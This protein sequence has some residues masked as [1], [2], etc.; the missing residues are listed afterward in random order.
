V[1]ELG[2]QVQRRAELRVLHAGVERPMSRVGQKQQN[3]GHVLGLHSGP[4]LAAQR[5]LRGAQRRQ[6]QQLLILGANPRLTLLPAAPGTKEKSYK[7]PLIRT[8]QESY[9]LTLIL[10]PYREESRVGLA[11]PRV[12]LSHTRLAVSLPMAV[13]TR[14]SSR[15]QSSKSSE[16]TRDR[17]VPRFRWMPEHSMQMSAPRFKLA[18]VGSETGCN[19]KTNTPPFNELQLT[20][21]SGT[22]PSNSLS[23]ALALTG[24]STVHTG[25]VSLCVADRLD[26]HSFALAV[27]A[28][29][30]RS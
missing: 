11:R 10:D 8:S 1:G 7:G 23:G 4:Q 14:V 13:S 28:Q 17:C 3:G 5:L 24:S 30:Q 16:R 22:P 19:S 9:T 15:G 25:R 18:H 26:G 2:R 20:P 6:E 21:Y 29:L 27:S 12:S